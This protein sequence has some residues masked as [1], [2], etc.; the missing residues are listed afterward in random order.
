MNIRINTEDKTIIV[1]NGTIGE[2]IKFLK[3]SVDD[4]EEYTIEDKEPKLY[5][6]PYPYYTYGG[7]N[8]S[9][10]KVTSSDYNFIGSGSGIATGSLNAN[11]IKY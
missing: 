7:I 8:Q 2:I 1:Y 11:N 9:D 4:W 6:S 5:V 3:H 10:L